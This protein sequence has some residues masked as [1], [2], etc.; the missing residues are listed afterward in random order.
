[1]A[2]II[3][4]L[5]VPAL[6]LVKPV[7]YFITGLM[8]WGNAAVI[9]GRDGWLFPRL[10]SEPS[11][12]TPPELQGTAA[13]LRAHGAALVVVSVPAKTAVYPEMLDG[14]ADGSL[15]RQPRI[16]AAL[17]ALA[18]AGAQ[19][20]DLGPALH[21]AKIDDAAQGSVFPG[22]GSWWTPRGMAHSASA[23]A[24]FIQQVRQYADLPLQPALAVLHRG[25]SRA[26]AGD[27]VAA[28]DSAR[29]QS[30]YPAESVPLVR[31][32]APESNEP[33]G[34][35]REAAVVLLG[36]DEVRLYDDPAL[37]YG[38]AGIPEGGRSSAGFPQHLAWL[39][40]TPLDIHTS[41]DGSLAAA[42]DW[43][44]ARPDE[45]RRRKKIVVWVIADGELLR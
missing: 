19:V 36:G 18:A 28:L 38:V 10:E 35:D 11:R 31:L 9:V 30:R 7:R 3:V 23:A 21:A 44:A 34:S 22:S 1:V 32:L 33:L 16:A 41:P 42:R 12:E 29:L 26:S 40:G 6:A 37:G 2:S 14:G 39:L 27:L 5:A 4:L 25:T 20:L 8:G 15:R 17:G 45:E 43:L 13:A 24:G